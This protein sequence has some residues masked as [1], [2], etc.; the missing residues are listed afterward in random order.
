[1]KTWMAIPLAIAMIAAH[2]SQS[3]AQ[4]RPPT[5]SCQADIK[6][7]CNFKVLR[8]ETVSACLKHNVSKL[9]PNCRTIIRAGA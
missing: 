3:L 9:S 8:P 7:L 6:K 4:Q 2:A 5:N 1:M